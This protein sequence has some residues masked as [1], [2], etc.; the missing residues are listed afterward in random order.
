MLYSRRI[1]SRTGRKRKVWKKRYFTGKRKNKKQYWKKTWQGRMPTRSTH[2]FCKLCTC[3]HL[4]LHRWMIMFHLCHQWITILQPLCPWIM[5]H[6]NVVT[7]KWIIMLHPHPLWIIILWP[8]CPFIMLHCLCPLCHKKLNKKEANKIRYKFS[9]GQLPF[10][11]KK[12]TSQVETLLRCSLLVCR[13]QVSHGSFSI[14]LFSQRRKE[15]HLIFSSFISYVYTSQS[16]FVCV[17]L[18]IYISCWDSDFR[19]SIGTLEIQLCFYV[20]KMNFPSISED[21]KFKIQ[22]RKI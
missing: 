17:W 21:P 5:L 16:T 1:R 11:T 20:L 6:N 8:C 7:S 10:T 22:K 18:I 13:G 12:K 15:S 14:T 19:F 2:K 9:N 3:L 4:H